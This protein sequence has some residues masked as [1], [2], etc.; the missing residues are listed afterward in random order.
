MQDYAREFYSSTAWKNTRTAYAKSVH[1]LCERCLR[2]GVYT[3]GEIVHHKIHITPDNILDP[4]IT[5]N[6]KNLELVCRE[7]HAEEHGQ[8]KRRYKIDELGRVICGE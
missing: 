8:R 7:C 1:N 3:P 2:K 4:V 6:F 5:L